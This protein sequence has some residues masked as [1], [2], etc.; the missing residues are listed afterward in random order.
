[1]RMH[2]K[3]L[4]LLLPALVFG[5]LACGDDDDDDS[6]D[7][8]TTPTAT[9]EPATAEPTETSQPTQEPAT[10][11]EP[12]T[13]TPTSVPP[14]FQPG[15]PVIINSPGDCVNLR[16]EPDAEADNIITCL[17]HGIAVEI[18]ENGPVTPEIHWYRVNSPEGEGYVSGEFL[19]ASGE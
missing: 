15:T 3:F 19:Q 4:L 7:G 5:A 2:L 10:A 16:S 8:G 9:T 13:G 12:P 18:L 17:G 1:M 14:G 11:T 6:G